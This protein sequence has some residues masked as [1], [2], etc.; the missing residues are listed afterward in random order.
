MLVFWRLRTEKYEAELWTV[1]V[2]LDL[3]DPI[4]TLGVKLNSSDTVSLCL[5]KCQGKNSAGA[6]CIPQK[7]GV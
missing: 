4:I 1:Y 5:S 6:T 2:S 7:L 3:G